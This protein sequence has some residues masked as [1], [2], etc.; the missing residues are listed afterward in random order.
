MSDSSWIPELTK[1]GFELHHANPP[2]QIAFLKWLPESVDNPVP[3]FAHHMIGVGGFVVNDKNEILVVSERYRYRSHWKLPGGYVDPEEHLG[4]A[5]TREVLEETGIKTEFSHI[6]GFRYNLS[7]PINGFGNHSF[8]LFFFRHGHK[9]NF[10]CSDIYFIVCLKPLNEDI[11]ICLREIS[12]SKWMP[13]R[14]YID[15]ELVHDMNKKFARKYL[16]GKDRNRVIGLSKIDLRI[17]DVGIQWVYTI[18][19]KTQ[20]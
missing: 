13:I 19:D 11:K 5:A 3:S 6:L 9:M 8:F 18:E 14:E 16:E 12:D 1:Q 20:K 17:K 15:H 2:N 4:E 7:W 10:D